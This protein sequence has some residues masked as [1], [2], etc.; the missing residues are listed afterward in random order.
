MRR[1]VETERWVIALRQFA[2][3]RCVKNEKLQNSRSVVL[4]VVIHDGR[5]GCNNGA[6]HQ[7]LAA[8]LLLR[9]D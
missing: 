1:F 8:L 4:V 6:I 7:V 2:T 9:A 3:A 5:R